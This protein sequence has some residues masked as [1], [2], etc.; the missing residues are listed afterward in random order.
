M[1]RNSFIK[2][3]FA[4]EITSKNKNK[5]MVE[6]ILL[7][8]KKFWL[9][10]DIFLYIIFYLFCFG[11]CFYFQLEKDIYFFILG[12]ALLFSILLQLLCLWFVDLKVWLKYSKEKDIEKVQFAKVKPGSNKG[13][14]ELCPIIKKEVI[15]DLYH[16]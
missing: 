5:K 1:I 12:I 4:K 14:T 8:K 11:L 6:I 3:V 13:K 10:L 15:V 9:R 7:K 2:K 16:E